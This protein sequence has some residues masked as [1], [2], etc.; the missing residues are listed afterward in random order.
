MPTLRYGVGPSR[1]RLLDVMRRNRNAGWHKECAAPMRCQ[2]EGAPEPGE[3]S[4][5]VLP[6]GA[7]ACQW[8]PP[9]VI[10]DW[11]NIGKIVKPRKPA[12]PKSVSM[13]E[14]TLAQNETIRR[15]TFQGFRHGDILS[16]GNP[17]HHRKVTGAFQR[18]GRKALNQA[19][20]HGSDWTE[21]TGR[22]G[23][24]TEGGPG[25]RGNSDKRDNCHTRPSESV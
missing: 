19:V 10:P 2:G 9:S 20:F 24:A 23:N 4:P 8:H 16:G 5:T 13:R 25:R 11:R 15:R 7:G 18:A 1:F 3:R 21:R 14:E 22:H 12:A 6:G 17:M